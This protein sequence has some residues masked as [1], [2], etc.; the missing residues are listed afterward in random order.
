VTEIVIATWNVEIAPWNL[1]RIPGDREPLH[2]EVLAGIDADILAL[3]E[4]MDLAYAPRLAVQLGMPHLFSARAP[5]AD[6]DTI[7]PGE[8]GLRIEHQVIL[9]RLPLR[10]AQVHRGDGTAM[11]NMP[12]LE[13][14][15]DLPGVAS[16]LGVFAVHLQVHPGGPGNARKS[17]ETAALRTVLADAPYPHIVLG[18]FNAWMPGHAEA[19]GL[20]DVNAWNPGHPD[21][22]APDW[23]AGWPEEHRR[24]YFRETMGGLLEDGYRD[25][26]A[27]RT[28]HPP[29]PSW[30]PDRPRIDHVMVTPDLAPH[31]VDVSVL[32][33]EVIDRAS[34]HRPVV[35]RLG[36]GATTATRAP[37]D[38]RVRD[39][40]HP[41][42]A[43]TDMANPT[44]AAFP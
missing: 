22:E 42:N 10:R 17:R 25:A 26:L 27:D 43:S 6:S 15:V 9:S 39:G 33:S 23:A 13:A 3:Q 19:Y 12:V 24:A 2:Y 16:G 5:G 18:D 44:F 1:R 8:P 30:M 31:V 20:G 4:V 36:L 11:N 14:W 32:A 7:E 40:T 28:G 34:D 35:V 37:D 38:V 29:A 21:W 41:G